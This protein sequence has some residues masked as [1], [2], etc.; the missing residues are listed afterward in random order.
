MKDKILIDICN[1]FVLLFF[2]YSFHFILFIITLFIGL[3]FY[4]LFGP[5][6]L[7]SNEVSLPKNGPSFQRKYVLRVGH[8]N[9]SRD[10]KLIKVVLWKMLVRCQSLQ[11][12]REGTL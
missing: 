11:V 9:L 4:S 6:K 1:V 12:S 5:T 10:I 8:S 3:S 2:V 7:V